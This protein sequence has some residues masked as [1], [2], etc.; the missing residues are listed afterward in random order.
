MMSVTTASVISFLKVV[1]IFT[2]LIGG[3]YGIVIPMLIPD[4]KTYSILI[5]GI[6]IAALIGGYIGY[7]VPTA[8]ALLIKISF[9]F[10]YAIAVAILVLLLSLFII[11]NVRG[12]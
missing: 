3:A 10:C 8:D 7:Q 11:L 5:V 9:G 4:Y 6:A 12:S 1:A 2:V